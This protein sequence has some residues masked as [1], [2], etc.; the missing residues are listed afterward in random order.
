MTNQLRGH[1]KRLGRSQQDVADRM[2]HGARSIV[3]DLENGAR[4]P[5]LGTL[6]SWASALGLVVTFSLDGSEIG[7]CCSMHNE[8]CEPPSEL[9]CGDCTEAAHPDHRDGSSCVLRAAAVMPA[10]AGWQPGDPVY[11]PDPEQQTCSACRCSWS[12]DGPDACPECGA[13]AQTGGDR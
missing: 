7:L 12:P 2:G 13:A 8:H 4:S 9:C 5:G 6:L 3:C 10:G 1:R 11:A